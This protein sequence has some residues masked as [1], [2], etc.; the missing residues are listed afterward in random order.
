MSLGSAMPIYNVSPASLTKRWGK[1]GVLVFPPYTV[2]V[3]LLFII[4]NTHGI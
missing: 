1:K 3:I 2:V 4:Y